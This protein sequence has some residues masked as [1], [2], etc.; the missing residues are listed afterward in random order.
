MKLIKGSIYS[1]GSVAYVP[2]IPWILSGTIRDN[3]IFGKDYDPIRYSA[4]LEACAL[5]TDISLTVGGDMAYIG[6]KGVNLSG[7]QR[8]RLALARA[9]YHGSDVIMLDDV[10]SAVD[11]QVASWILSNAI[12]G[13]LMDRKTRILCTHNI[14]VMTVCPC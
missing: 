10:L 8:A 9:V 5:D 13:P 7:G 3:V 2:Q 6:E 4:V 14:Q 1:R 11:A 12:L